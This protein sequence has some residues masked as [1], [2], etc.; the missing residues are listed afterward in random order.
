MIPLDSHAGK[1]IAV[2]GLGKTGRAAA[3]A[4]Q[5]SGAALYLWDDAPERA[6]ALP[7]LL[8]DMMQPC[9]DWPWQTLDALLVSPGIP[10]SHPQPHE[11]VTLARRHGVRLI[12]DI[13]LLCEACP[14]AHYIAITGTNGKST[15]T[16]LIGHILQQAGRRA[17]AGGNLGTPALEMAPLDES[18]YYVLE[19]SSFQL[20]LLPPTHFDVAVWLNLSPDHLDRHG[21]MDGYIAAKKHIFAGQGTGDVA[22]IGVDDAYSEAVARELTVAER[23]PRVVPVSVTQRV[24]GGVRVEGG[25]LYGPGDAVLDLTGMPSLRGTHNHQ[26]A[27]AAYAACRSAGLTHAQI[28]A[29]MRSFPG[30]AHRMQRVGEQGG[31]VFVNDSKATNADAAAKSLGS[32][33]P[34]FWLAGGVAKAGGIA[35]LAPYFPRIAHAFL[36]GEARHAFAQTLG[37]TVAHSLHDTLEDATRAA[38]AAAQQSGLAQPVVLLA[39]ACASFDQFAN[40]EQRGE[41][42]CATVQALMQEARDAG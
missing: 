3:E 41:A 39:P 42:F 21:D 8:A 35:P 27:A 33:N 4:L 34:V 2:L 9:A 6:G 19:L 23:A 22:V 29:G 10:L 14:A 25:M 15:T 11:A 36:Y 26:N 18:G 37:D 13:E 28:E 1:Q 24:Q 40:F 32:Y 16:A 20:D 7:A 17:E 30:L 5:S 31:V 38:Y 12:S